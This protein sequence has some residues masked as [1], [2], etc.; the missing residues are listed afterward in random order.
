MGEREVQPM[1][2][3]RKIEEL[4]RGAGIDC[5]RLIVEVRDGDVTMGGVVRSDIERQLGRTKDAVLDAADAVR[6]IQEAVGTGA[7]SSYLGS[8]YLALGRALQTEGE[9]DAAQTAFRSAAEHLEKTLGTDH[10]DTRTSRQLARF[11][12]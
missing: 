2:V 5:S 8:A 4:L 10:P 1:D 7:F 11:A 6:Q 9:T 3:K 12:Q